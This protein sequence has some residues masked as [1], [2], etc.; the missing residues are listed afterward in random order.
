MQTITQHI[1]LQTHSMA[2]ASTATPVVVD[3]GTLEAAAIAKI[4]ES[5]G[6]TAPTTAQINTM[7]HGMDNGELAI[8][9]E[10]LMN[11]SMTL[12]Q[13]EAD[14]EVYT[15]NGPATA[16]DAQAATIPTVAQDAEAIQLLGQ[17]ALVA[18]PF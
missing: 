10:A 3:A 6:D 13:V 9:Y 2:A 11:P 7:A 14:I 12:N 16:F 1:G 8:G 4:L 18:F 5:L 17:H 15:I